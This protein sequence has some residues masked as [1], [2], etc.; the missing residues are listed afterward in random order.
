MVASFYGRQT[1]LGTLRR[2]YPVSLKGATLAM[3]MET[4]ARLGLSGRPL[5]LELD[6]L[7]SLRVPAILH[8]DM[9]HFVVLRQAGRSALIIHDPAFGSRRCN[10]G[11]A[12]KHF[13]GV[14]LELTPDNTF[15]PHRSS[16][17][18]SLFDFFGHISG[19]V[20]ALA[21]ILVLSV[22]LQLYVPPARSTCRSSSIMRSRRTT[23]IYC[24]FSPAGSGCSC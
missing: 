16:P 4:A 23:T 18:L 12:S 11:E 2:Q 17:K 8:W 1:D 9:N 24:W 6:H 3:V 14:A 22:I 5:R 21:Q 10:L 13:T 19:L 15:R 7:Q 20:P